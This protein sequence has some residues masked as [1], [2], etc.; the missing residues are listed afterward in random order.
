MQALPA[1]IIEPGSSLEFAAGGK[2]LMLMQPT[3]DTAAGA[4]ITLEIHYDSG[5]L[6]IV[7]AT[8]QKRTPT[9]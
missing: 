9:E 7:S 1:V 6:L 8:M 2:H 3:A 5:G 4:N